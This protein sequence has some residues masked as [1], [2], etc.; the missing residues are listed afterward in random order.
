VA[1]TRISA[2]TRL[3]E[4]GVSP[5]DLLPIADLSA[6]ET[7]AITAKDLLEGVV[8]NM[9]AGSIPVA[10]IDFSSG[11]S[12]SN[13]Q[14]SQGD[15]VLGRA[16]GSGFAQEL[17][18]TAVGR[19]LLAAA[20]AA[21]QRTTLGLGTLA[22]RSGSWVDGSNF[23]GTS[24]G[25]NTGDQLIVLTGDVTGSG[26]GTFPATI[27]AGAVV[28]AKLG[29]GAVSTRALADGGVTAAKLADQSASVVLSGAPTTPGKFV[30][31]GGFNTTTGSAYTYTATGWVQHAGIQTLAVT[32]SGTPLAVTVTSGAAT[33]VSIDLDNQIANTVWAAP[34]GADG[35]P[36]FR[37]L[38]GGDLPIALSSTVGA[39]MPGAGTSVAADGKLSIAT[40]TTLG[41]VIVKGPSLSVAADGALS[42]TNSAAPAGSYAKVTTDA[43][44]HVVA[45][46]V[47]VTDADIAS[48]D[49]GKITTG[50]LPAARL[51][52]GSITRQMLA[53]YSIAFIQ[54]TTPPTTG[55]HAGTIWLQEST[56]ALRMWNSNSWFSIGIGRLSAENLRYCGTFDAATGLITGVTQ[57]GTVEGLKTGDAI[58]AA[59]DARTGIYFVCNVAGN[60]TPVLTGTSFDPGDWILC[61]GAA[62]GYSRIDTLSGGG[63]GGGSTVSRLDDL[64]DVTLT[65]PAEGDVLQF[66]SGQ[67]INVP[68]LDAGTY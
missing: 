45:G 47:Q 12:A 68:F 2:L 49:A 62:P 8:I 29:T 64:L 39:V 26:K 21:G 53:D 4:A 54:E 20:D 7:K 22:L 28:E 10:K 5:T 59:T 17:A 41:G 1:D 6:S 25:T 16:S 63:G 34:N 19:A 13:I 36:L 42:H 66:R 57:F 40:P 35:K 18:C 44:G 32:D 23:S 46:A 48:V 9:D 50:F 55:I 58:P 33:S 60:A 15:V 67:W 52:A 31:Q 30:G 51:Q 61:N 11:V 65:T 3:P 27:A 37:K 14:V 43:A 24:S 56:G 38:L